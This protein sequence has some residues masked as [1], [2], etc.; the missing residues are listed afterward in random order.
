ML[1]GPMSEVQHLDRLLRR[2]PSEFRAWDLVRALTDEV[3]P[4]YPCT[5]GDAAGV[6]WARAAFRQSGLER[7]WTEKAEATLWERGAES[8]SLLLPRRQPVVLT[9]LGGSVG[10][11]GRLDAE[12][13]TFE[14]IGAL[15]A[16]PRDAVEGRIV[17]LHHVMPRRRDGTGYNDAAAI[18]TAGPSHAAAKGA[19]AFLVRSVGTSS[20]RAAHTGSLWYRD[21]VARI[22][23]AALAT[24]DADLLHRACSSGARVRAELALG[25]KPLPVGESENVLAELPG[26]DLA[27]EIVLLGAHLDSWDLGAGA[28]DDGAGCA[29]AIEVARWFAEL[30]ARPRRTVRFVLFANEELGIG[31]GKAYAS[32]H[33]AE[34]PKHVAAMEADQGDGA[35]WAL[36]VPEG[37][38]ERAAT[39]ALV[40][41]LAPFG[42]GLDPGPAR[43]G[44]DI[45]PLRGL[46]VPFVDLRQDAT[47]YFDFHHTENDVLE[48]VS[49]ADIDAA[50]RAFAVAV[51]T[52][53]NADAT[54]RV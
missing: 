48:N 54:F 8:C 33:A 2:A 16:A 4:R 7:V 43:G 27:S 45:S 30:P 17:Y 34:A 51:W 12:V 39:T 42:I 50:T 24:P 49:R 18:R 40:S 46:G 10:T 53:A 1:R 21:G 31:G 44:V 35:P 15:D 14:S 22:P 9:A 47:R 29:I 25:C 41:A 5:P 32:A 26:T 37:A 36:R 28:L 52:L 23:A 13:V 6:A 3:G 38:R 11:E 19:A 20:V